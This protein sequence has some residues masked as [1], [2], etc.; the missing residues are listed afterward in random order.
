MFD[1]GNGDG[2]L[3]TDR[4]NLGADLDLA[5][6]QGLP[7]LEYLVFR[8]A[9]KGT[10]MRSGH[11]PLAALATVFIAAAASTLPQADATPWPMAP[12]QHAAAGPSGAK[13]TIDPDKVRIQSDTSKLKVGGTYTCTQKGETNRISIR[14]KQP[15]IQPDFVGYTATWVSC[16]GT[17][18]PW[19]ATMTPI[20]D[21]YRTE[22]YG[23]WK[24]GYWADISASLTVRKGKIGDYLESA[25]AEP[26][27]GYLRMEG[28]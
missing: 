11:Q 16:P 18:Q 17:D 9:E 8:P 5:S 20:K 7:V 28:D 2:P 21:L 26:Y 14:G 13:L 1:T 12:I 4:L 25:K 23:N 3:R 15:T 27:G 22:Q 10:A 6:I 24:P 19:E